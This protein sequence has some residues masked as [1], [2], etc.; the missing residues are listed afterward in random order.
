MTRASGHECE[1]SAEFDVFI[2]Y[3][4]EDKEGF[5]C[6]LALALEVRSEAGDYD[7]VGSRA[8]CGGRRCSMS[9]PQSSPDGSHSS[10]SSVQG[11]DRLQAREADSAVTLE[12]VTLEA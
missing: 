11:P 7:T 10:T 2:S 12:A 1:E 4:Y 5:V 6:E 3:A 8:A 9:Q